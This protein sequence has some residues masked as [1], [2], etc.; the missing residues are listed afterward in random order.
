MHLM[1]Y[2]ITLP[3]DYDMGIIH[4]RVATRGSRT[5][6]FPG[7]GL[8]AYLVREIGVDRSPVNQYAPFY[9]WAKLE[10]MN[11]FVFGPGFEGIRADFGRPAVRTW[12]AIAVQDGA[13]SDVVPMAASRTFESVDPALPLM[14]HTEQIAGEAAD[15]ANQ[16]G[17]VCVA[18]GIDPTTWQ[19][20]TLTLW[21][22]EVPEDALGDRYAVLHVSQPGR[23]PGSRGSRRS[24]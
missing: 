2:E 6:D 22:A 3:A 8:K 5:D 10:G 14:E 1:Q 4:H 23:R 9:V 15:A 11:Q 21:A 18:T 7:L 16:Q 13:S 20:V 19:C 12:H 17:V 24:Q